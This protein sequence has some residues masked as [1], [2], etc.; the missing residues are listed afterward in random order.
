[1]PP[2]PPLWRQPR[3]PGVFA[4]FWALYIR[5][6]RRQRRAVAFALVPQALTAALLMAIFDLASP[7]GIAGQMP[8]ADVPITLG[9]FIAP[10]LIAITMLNIAFQTTAFTILHAK[11][12]GFIDIELMA[13][14]SAIS[15]LFAHGLLGTTMGVLVGLA[16]GVVLA[17]VV[18]MPFPD[19]LQAV[20]FAV[21]GAW[22]ISLFGIFA[23]LWARKWDSLSAISTFIV[24]P[25]VF[26]SGAFAPVSGFEAPFADL[27]ANQPFHF[28]I[29]GVRGGL[30]GAQD[31]SALVGA[32]GMGAIAAVG[33]WAVGRLIRAGF[34]TVA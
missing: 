28:V 15:R 13:P 25:L 27:V 24:T 30:T 17:F 33:A 3:A 19:P 11:I 22:C 8:G 23:G 12:D 4:G 32:L 16:V 31:A 6:L 10:G 18:D 2:A 5:E 26:L 1:V 29:D 20:L 14:L 7:E 34:N 21:L 9:A